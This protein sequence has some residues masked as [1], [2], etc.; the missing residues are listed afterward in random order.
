MTAADFRAWLAHMAFKS[1]T[2]AARALGCGRNSIAAW[3]KKAPPDY[4]ALACAALAYGLPAW[5]RN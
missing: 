1:D 3:K 2:E 5:R 4:I